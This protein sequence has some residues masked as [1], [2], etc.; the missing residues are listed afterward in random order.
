MPLPQLPGKLDGRPYVTPR[1]LH[2]YRRSQG[3]G[4]ADPPSTIVFSWQ[5]S[6]LERVRAE[7]TTVELPTVA[8]VVLQI[9][10]GIGFLRLPVGAPVVGIIVEE[11]AAAGVSTIVGVG[12]AGGLQEELVPG[13]AVVCSAALRDEGVSHHYAP[14]ARFAEPSPELTASLRS[15]L[16]AAA[17]GPTWT[18]DAPYR[19]TAEE[20]A[21]YRSEGILT[22]DMEA[23][24]LFTVGRHVGVRTASVFCVSDVLCGL[25]W[26]PH[27][28]AV[29]VTDALW[30]TFEALAVALAG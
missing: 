26:E 15:V 17:Y 25:E 2:D 16:P 14:P 11:L 24:A 22:V 29:G 7:R 30:R 10:P 20:I 5:G 3:T 27:F 9:S 12:T 18:T 4:D 13:D 19:E 28:Q 6:L 1:A 23:A 21:A 8:G